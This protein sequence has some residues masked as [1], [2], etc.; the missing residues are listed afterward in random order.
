VKDNH[1]AEPLEL[2][3]M[4]DRDRHDDELIHEVML[5]VR[6]HCEAGAGR[7]DPDQLER[8]ADIVLRVAGDDPDYPSRRDIEY[9]TQTIHSLDDSQDPIARRAH[10]Q[11]APGEATGASLQALIARLLVAANLI[12]RRQR[13][14]ARLFLFGY[15]TAE[16]AQALGVPRTTVQSRWRRARERLQEAL[17]EVP[18]GDWLALPSASARISAEAVR[19]TFYDDRHRPR[20]HAPKHCPEGRERCATTGVCAFRGAGVE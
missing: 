14:V 9:T 20:Y 10:G 11:P 6:R 13:E 7:L 5:R 4:S 2:T 15:T 17:R 8:L 16:I 12:S 1:P 3:Q 18:I 19:A